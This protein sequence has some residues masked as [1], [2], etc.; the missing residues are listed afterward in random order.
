MAYENQNKCLGCGISIPFVHEDADSE[1]LL[2]DKCL[3]E[4]DLKFMCK[5]CH[6]EKV[7]ER[8]ILCEY[9]MEEI[10]ET[11]MRDCGDK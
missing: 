2:C 6:V 3:K 8:E 10:D 11:D 5:N 4:D 1:A 7:E 9:C